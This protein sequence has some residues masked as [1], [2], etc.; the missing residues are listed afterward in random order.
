M[1][2]KPDIIDYINKYFAIMLDLI[3]EKNILQAKERIG[4]EHETPVFIGDEWKEKT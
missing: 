1:K 4:N 2:L 3:K